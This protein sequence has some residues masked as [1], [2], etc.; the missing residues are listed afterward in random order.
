MGGNQRKLATR[1]PA[2]LTSEVCGEM[3]ALAVD[4]GGGCQGPKW[5]EWVHQMLLPLGI[6]QMTNGDLRGKVTGG[7]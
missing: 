3:G 4:G 6:S 7:S 2:K 1:R 5:V